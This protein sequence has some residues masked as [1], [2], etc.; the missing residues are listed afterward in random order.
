M[1]NLPENILWESVYR[2][3]TADPLLAGAGGIMNVPPQQLVNR[4]AWLKDQ[5]D[6]TLFNSG[7]SVIT[8]NTSLTSAFCGKLILATSVSTFNI[9]LPAVSSMQQ[10]R[11]FIIAHNFAANVCYKI[12]A[13]GTDTLL[14]G[15][16][17][18]ASI[19]LKPT[20]VLTIVPRL[21]TWYALGEDLGV[22]KV[23][24]FG[25]SSPPLGWLLAQGQA[26]SRLEYADLFSAIGTIFG[27][28][29]GSTTFNLPDLRGEFI[30]GWDNG[31]GVDAGRVLGS[32]QEDLF[33]SHAHQITGSNVTSFGGAGAV[34]GVSPSGTESGGL[35][36]FT[37]GTE[38][39]PRNIALNYC[40]K[41]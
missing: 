1:A 39:R 7:V 38:T 12:E 14:S 22:G 23:E 28:G 15:G 3:E 27:A 6:K 36:D 10:G 35:T 5:S 19:Y 41:F 8:S 26:V 18:R 21:N 16:Q 40:I 20:Q 25:M 17:T 29:D 34:P 33:K 4:T 2:W 32:A 37:G 11:P 13:A 9:T 30:R 31:R 24:A